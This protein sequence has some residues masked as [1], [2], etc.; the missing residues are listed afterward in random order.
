MIWMAFSLLVNLPLVL[1][2]VKET[3]YM[4]VPVVGVH[5]V[6]VAFPVP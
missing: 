4:T 2:G 3:V 1:G 5:A 6:G